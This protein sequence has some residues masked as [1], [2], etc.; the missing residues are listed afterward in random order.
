MTPK[1]I[2]VL[3]DGN[4]YFGNLL[5][6]QLHHGT[7]AI[8]FAFRDKVGRV[9]EW[10]RSFVMLRDF[11]FPDPQVEKRIPKGES[12]GITYHVEGRKLEIKEEIAGG[13]ISRR[14]LDVPNPINSHLFTIHFRNMDILREITPTDDDIIFSPKGFGEQVAMIFSL[15]NANGNGFRDPNFDNVPV[16]KGQ[17]FDIDLSPAPPL[18]VAVISDTHDMKDSDFLITSTLRESKRS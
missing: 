9:K 17:I 7:H 2:R 5:V 16:E 6:L 12:W 4:R 10:E 11:L 14:L 13:E 15:V 3:L 8:K 1:K 18:K